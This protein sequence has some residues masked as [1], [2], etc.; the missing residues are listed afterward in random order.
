MKKH[1]LIFLFLLSISS[2][3]EAQDVLYTITGN[4]IQ[5]KV[6]EITSSEVKYKD[7]SNLEGPTYVLDSKEIVLIKFA[8]GTTQIINT[9]PP[10]LE[11]TQEVESIATSSS[12][13]TSASIIKKKKELPNLYYIN[14]NLLSINALALA[15]GDFTLIY[16]REFYNN[17][18]ALT[19]LGGYNFNTR[20]GALNGAIIDSRE[21][22][23]KNYDLGL[24][25]N[26]MPKN[27]KRVQY[28][29]GL[30]GKYMNYTYDKVIDNGNNQLTYQKAAGYQIAIMLT[31]GWMYRISPNFNFKIFGSI[32]VPINYPTLNDYTSTKSNS[33]NPGSTPTR[34]DPNPF[35]NLPKIYLGYCFGYRF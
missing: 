32:G 20:M 26:F 9:N 4:K 23:K 2:W 21:R 6:L 28:F 30:L 31:N 19:F 29:V 3:L 14:P 27:T 7:F 18:I 34:K 12:S 25:I 16:D 10:A 11:P 5:G 33:G 13:S 1:K 15:N 24:G 35:L 22:A 17:K 8:N